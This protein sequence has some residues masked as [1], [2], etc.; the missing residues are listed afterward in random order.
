MSTGFFCELGR[1]GKD[2]VNLQFDDSSIMSELY[3]VQIPAS[4][5]KGGIM[6]LGTFDK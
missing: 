4:S 2:Q 6:K 3:N 1:I 5:D